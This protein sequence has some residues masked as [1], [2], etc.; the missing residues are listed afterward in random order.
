LLQG[1]HQA[2]GRGK[3]RRI[4]DRQLRL[5]IAKVAAIGFF[6]IPSWLF[7]QAGLK[8]SIDHKSGS[9]S[10]AASGVA[11]QVLSASPAILVDGKWIVGRE[12]PQHQVQNAQVEGPLGTANEQTVTYTDLAGAPDLILRIRTYIAQPFGEIQI[13]ARNAKAATRHVERLRLLDAAGPEILRLGGDLA[14]DR[15]TT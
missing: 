8:V 5:R 11:G 12:Y 2:C 9:Y 7:A 15:V 1:H 10:I 6:A 13:T 14:P 3:V 4:H